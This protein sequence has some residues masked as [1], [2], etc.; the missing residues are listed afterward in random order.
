MFKL[1]SSLVVFAV[2]QLDITNILFTGTAGVSPAQAPSR[3][4]ISDWG[5]LRTFGSRYALAAGETPALPVKTLS[6]IFGL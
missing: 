2:A 5:Q 6:S 3:A 4:R 1:L